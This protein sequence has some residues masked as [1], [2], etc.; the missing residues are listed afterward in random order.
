MI[1]KFFSLLLLSVLFAACGQVDPGERATFVKWGT[2]YQAC[3]NPGLYW[4][5]PISTNMDLINVQ[6]QA[7]EAKDLSAATKDLQEVHATVVVN[8]VLDGQNCHKMVTEVGHQYREKVLFPALQDAL[9]AGTAHFNIEEIIR[10]RGRLRAEVT[11]A[12]QARVKPFYI[13]VNDEGVNLTN[14]GLSEAY[15]KAVENKQVAEQNVIRATR[16]AEAVRE[17]AKGEADS[18]R[19]SAKGFADRLKIEGEAQLAYN[20][21]VSESLTDILVRNR[22]VDAW[23]QGGSQVPQIV[24]GSGGSLLIQV[25]TPK[26]EK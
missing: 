4:Y 26:T 6:V 8:Y 5:N 22:S 13:T 1:R 10:E 16:E 18:V 25:P 9:K 24:T 11:K 3:Y 17:K 7:F 19:E 15:M 21:K 20:R 2:M 12:L 14:F 23:A